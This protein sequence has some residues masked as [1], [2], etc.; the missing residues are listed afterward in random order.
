MNDQNDQ[1]ESSDIKK[2][3]TAPLDLSKILPLLSNETTIVPGG[4]NRVK[5]ALEAAQ[6]QDDGSLI[7]DLHSIALVIRG[8]EEPL[9]FS[10]ER[11]QMI[12]GRFD[13]RTGE[14]PDVDLTHLGA[15]ERGVSRRHA[16]LELKGGYLYLTDLDSANGTFLQRERLAPYHPTRLRRGDEILLGRLAVQIIF[17]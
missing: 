6:Q 1:N 2:G 12:L 16:R 13:Q 10:A 7:N 3:K 14:R 17:D 5:R 9:H 8:M 11:P 4:V 15:T